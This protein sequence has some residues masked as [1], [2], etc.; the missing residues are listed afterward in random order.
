[1]ATVPGGWQVE[2][3]ERSRDD[4]PLRSFL[5]G[6]DRRNANQAAALLLKLAARGNQLRPPDSQ[7]VAD[8]LYELRGHQVRIFYMF[9]QGPPHRPARRHHQ[10]AKPHPPAG[11]GA[12][13][14]VPGGGAAA[15]PAPAVAWSE[16][17]AVHVADVTE[18]LYG[19]RHGDRRRIR[20]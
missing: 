9:L 14:G 5:A 16:A 17:T 15:R 1:M 13:E 6:L 7:Q 10:E 19:D 11:S 20:V 18:A 4:V 3:Y 2:E 8:N 12:R